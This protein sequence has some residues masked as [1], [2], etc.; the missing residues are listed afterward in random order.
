MFDVPPA[1]ADE[2][3]PE[4]R[5]RWAHWAA[6]YFGL[7]GAERPSAARA[8]HSRMTAIEA[9]AARPRLMPMMI[10]RAMVVA[11]IF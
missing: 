4:F 8:A 10:V 5:G 6:H 2:F 7:S 1:L 9:A 3:L 11:V